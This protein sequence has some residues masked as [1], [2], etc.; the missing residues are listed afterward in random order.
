MLWLSLQGPRRVLEHNPIP[1]EILER[2]TLGFPIRV[3]RGDTLKPGC[4]HLG[5]TGFPLVVIGKV[6]DQQVILGRGFADLV[7]AMGRELQMVG[8][9]GMSKDD[10]IEA[11]MVFKLGEDCEVQPCGIHLGNSG[12]MVGGSGDAEHSTRLHSSASSSS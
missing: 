12:Q 6:E 10:T 5:T 2:L 7:S 11:V 3:I 4:E 9:L 8:L 1:I